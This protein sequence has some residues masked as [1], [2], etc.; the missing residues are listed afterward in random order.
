MA[1]EVFYSILLQSEGKNI[2]AYEIEIEMF[3]FFARF[4]CVLLVPFILYVFSGLLPKLQGTF[5]FLDFMS[6]VKKI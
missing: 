3:P 4:T 1:V 6:N 5:F 2:I